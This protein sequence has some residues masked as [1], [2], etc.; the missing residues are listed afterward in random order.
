M[1]PIQVRAASMAKKKASNTGERNEVHP[2]TLT[3]DSTL[4]PGYE[5]TT[6]YSTSP[7]LIS[8]CFCYIFYFI[9]SIILF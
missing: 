2:A 9:A 5:N 1:I 6:H 4:Q 3:T 7:T 8:L